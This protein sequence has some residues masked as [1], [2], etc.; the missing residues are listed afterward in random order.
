TDFDFESTDH[1]IELRRRPIPRR[2]ICIDRPG[3][4]TLTGNIEAAIHSRFTANAASKLSPEEQMGKA[5]CT[6]VGADGQ[7]VRGPIIDDPAL[8]LAGS[9]EE[10]SVPTN[11]WYELGVDTVHDS[12][13]DIPVGG[14]IISVDD[15]PV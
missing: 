13:L 14:I 10:T 3:S 11:K 2:A 12:A 8:A 6:L 5:T 15:I 9:T 1:G 4:R 7:L